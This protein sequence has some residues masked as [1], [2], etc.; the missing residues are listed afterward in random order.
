MRSDERFDISIRAV[1]MLLIASDLVGAVGLE[2]RGDLFSAAINWAAAAIL[3]SRLMR[4]PAISMAIFPVWIRRAAM[5]LALLIAGN[6]LG[7]WLVDPS[8]AQALQT[9]GALIASFAIG[10]VGWTWVRSEGGSDGP[11]GSGFSL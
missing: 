11:G 9:S 5:F 2:L 1:I 3:S 8:V 7:H 10:L 4:A 6:S